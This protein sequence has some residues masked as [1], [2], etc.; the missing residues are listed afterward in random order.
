MATGPVTHNCPSL[1]TGCAGVKGNVPQRLLCL[2]VWSQ[3]VELCGYVRRLVDSLIVAYIATVD[4]WGWT[5]KATLD[6]DASPVSLRLDCLSHEAAGLPPLQGALNWYLPEL[7]PASYC[8]LP[9][10]RGKT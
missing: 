8:Q 7:T 4:H 6:S 9:S 10:H 3:M 5:L 1:A 2:D